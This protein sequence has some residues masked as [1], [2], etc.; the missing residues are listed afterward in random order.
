ML[1]QTTN[2]PL[3][4]PPE[5]QERFHLSRYEKMAIDDSIVKGSG[6]ITIPSRE[7]KLSL[8]VPQ[9]ESELASQVRK[10]RK[11]IVLIE[12]NGDLT[13]ATAFKIEFT[14]EALS[15][16]L[17][18]IQFAIYHCVNTSAGI[19]EGLISLWPWVDNRETNMA[20]TSDDVSSRFD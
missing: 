7:E 14:R 11:T 6:S 19:M 16:L 10:E 20:Q 15:V 18:V 5:S 8:R 17:M 4:L 12:S 3:W 9:D 13:I 2:T 1:L